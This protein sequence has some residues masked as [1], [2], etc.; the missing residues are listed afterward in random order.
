MKLFNRNSDGDLTLISEK[1]LFGNDYN[2][3][4][5]RLWEIFVGINFQLYFVLA[6]DVKAE[7][8]GKIAAIEEIYTKYTYEEINNI[9]TIETNQDYS[10]GIYY[11]SIKLNLY[12]DDIIMDMN[13]SAPGG[14]IPPL[15]TN[16]E[17]PVTNAIDLQSEIVITENK[18]LLVFNYN[19]PPPVYIIK[20][21][22]LDNYH[23]DTYDEFSDVPIDIKNYITNNYISIVITQVSKYI[24]VVDVLSKNNYVMS[25]NITYFLGSLTILD[26]NQNIINPN[27]YTYNN[28][29]VD[30]HELS[31]SSYFPL[32][33]QI[34]YYNV[35]AVGL[36]SAT[37]KQENKPYK[38][39]N[40]I[41]SIV[42]LNR[43]LEPDKYI[44]LH[45]RKISV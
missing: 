27:R 33:L 15:T 3:L 4:Q 23:A 44:V 16:L 25:D 28:N 40:C 41:S 14:I 37:I 18:S 21:S 7:L 29:I 6:G 34:P 30:F 20:Q 38:L 45:S 32:T 31:Y 39:D 5:Q 2:T 1:T 26:K 10:T 35:Y 17:Y 36:K 13:I 12:R 42:T 22:L 11:I 9:I 24:N 8:F 19:V 43:E